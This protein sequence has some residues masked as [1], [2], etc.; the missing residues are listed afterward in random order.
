MSDR[1]VVVFQRGNA[2]RD[3]RG[4]CSRLLTSLGCLE[5]VLFNR[6]QKMTS[7]SLLNGGSVQMSCLG[8]MQEC[9]YYI[10]K[11]YENGLFKVHYTVRSY[12]QSQ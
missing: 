11:M 7:Q 5:R 1:Y 8:K 3:R 12:L 6:Y 4:F 2:P 10:A 9:S